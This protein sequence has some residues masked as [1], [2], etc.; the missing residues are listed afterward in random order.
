MPLR[1][2]IHRDRALEKISISYLPGEFVA[3]KLVPSVPVKRE[4]DVYYVYSND[5]MILEETLRSPG[6]KANRATYTMSTSSY[7]LEEHALSEIVP[8]RD[9]DN[10]DKPINLEID[11]TEILTRKI[12]IR[13]EREASTALQTSGNYNNSNSLTSTMAWTANTTVSNPITQIESATA[14]IIAS[15]GY[16]PN[17]LVIDNNTFSGAKVHTSIVDRVK[18]T[19]ADS[20]T[21][22]MLAKLFD[23]EQVLVARAVYES[24]EEGLTSSLGAIWTNTAVLA[25]YEKAPGLKKPS[26]A[27][28]FMKKREGAPYRVRKWYEDADEGTMIEVSSIFQFKPVATACAYLIIDTT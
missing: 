3:D 14:K 6:T 5:T 10:A 16:S 11:M 8:N 24:A 4:S 25:Y 2:Q 17:R 27:Y 7:S 23:I 1:Q 12:L 18:Y 28:Q 22:N 13:R 15:S 26:A 9:K 21:E 19:S 20:I